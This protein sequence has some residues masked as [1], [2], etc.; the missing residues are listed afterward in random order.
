MNFAFEGDGNV[1]LLP[2]LGAANFSYNLLKAAAGDYVVIG[3][4]IFGEAK[5][6]HVLSEAGT[7]VALSRWLHSLWLKRVD[8]PRRWSAPGIDALS[9]SAESSTMR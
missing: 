3:P 7:V 9:T 8:E 2:N 6:V 4:I 1:L 5:P